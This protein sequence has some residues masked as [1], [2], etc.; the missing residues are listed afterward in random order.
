[1][2]QSFREAGW[3]LLAPVIILGGLRSG[4]LLGS[5]TVLL[6]IITAV[7]LIAGMLLG[8]ISIFLAFLPGVVLWL[9]VIDWAAAQTRQG[10]EFSR[11]VWAAAQ[12]RLL[13]CNFDV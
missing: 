4:L 1:M 11:W 10:N 8:A 3:G 2:W 13:D 5:E 9:P 6:L 7:L 12:S